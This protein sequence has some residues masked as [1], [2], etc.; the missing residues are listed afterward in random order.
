MAKKKKNSIILYTDY[1]VQL[2]TLN[3]KQRGTLLTALLLY[4]DGQPLPEMD[5]VTN[6]CFLFISADIDRANAHY[7]EIVAKRQAAIKKRWAQD[8][9]NRQKSIQMYTNVRE[10]DKDT[11]KDK[12]KDN[13]KDKDKEREINYIGDAPAFSPSLDEIREYVA[14]RSKA[15]GIYPDFTPERFLKYYEARDWT[16]NGAK[17]T[18][19][20]ALVDSWIEKPTGNH[21][22]MTTEEDE[23]LKRKAATLLL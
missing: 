9:G 12:E 7:D 4:Q 23:E 11:V 3:M 15:D 6:L 1:L 10:K 18:N 14:E 22:A 5:D 2:K 21:S 8:D 13:V 19:W 20:K 17:V 16:I